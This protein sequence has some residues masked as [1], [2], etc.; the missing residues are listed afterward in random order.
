MT[1]RA[2]LIFVSAI[3]AIFWAVFVFVLWT[4]NPIS[5]NWIGLGLFYL[6]L[7]F[8]LVGTTALVGF[9]V[10]FVGL[11]QELA[12]RSVKEAFRQSF[13][14]ALFIV[15]ILWLLSKNLFN[16]LNLIFLLVG[17]SVLEFL[18]LGYAGQPKE[19]KYEE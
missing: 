7:F 14:F 9:L 16:W 17:L 3:T 8:S 11:K 19:K 15:T 5:T 1:L 4:V 2:Y 6:T 13:L 10:R 12:F 18:L